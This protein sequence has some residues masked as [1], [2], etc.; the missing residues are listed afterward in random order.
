MILQYPN[1]QHIVDGS[2]TDVNKFT[3]Q[4]ARNKLLVYNSSLRLL[5]VY[6]VDLKT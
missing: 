6:I 1:I 4:V 3:L 5:L 2:K